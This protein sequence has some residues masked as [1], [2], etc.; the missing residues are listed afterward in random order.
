MIYHVN[1][2]NKLKSILQNFIVWNKIYKE[3]FPDRLVAG[4]KILALPT[5]VRIHLREFVFNFD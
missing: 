1:F 5:V 3:L 2:V 4:L